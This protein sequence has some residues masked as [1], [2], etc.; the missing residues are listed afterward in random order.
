MKTQNIA[1]KQSSGALQLHHLH[2][3]VVEINSIIVS[4][5]AVG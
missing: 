4:M 1:I 5:P 2:D 3:A